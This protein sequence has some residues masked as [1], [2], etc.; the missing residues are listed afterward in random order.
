M[1][2]SRS[3]ASFSISR[4]EERLLFREDL[5]SVLRIVSNCDIRMQNVSSVASS[6]VYIAIFLSADMLVRA[7]SFCYC[8][9]I[10][11]FLNP[12]QSII[13][14]GHMLQQEQVSR[15]F[16]RLPEGAGGNFVQLFI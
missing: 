7:L 3:D 11:P 8:I 16:R 13:G 5:A 14:E 15:Q 6:I 4:D 9:E 10:Q 12:M 2:I 1:L